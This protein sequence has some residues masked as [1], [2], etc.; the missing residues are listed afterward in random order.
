[1]QNDSNSIIFFI[2]KYLFL[3]KNNNDGEVMYLDFNSFKPTCENFFNGINNFNNLT[4]TSVIKYEDIT[5]VLT[6]EQYSKLCNPSQCSFQDIIDIYNSL[7][8]PENVR[9][10]IQ[11]VREE[12]DFLM[13][14]YSLTQSDIDKIFSAVRF[15]DRSAVYA[16]CDN[17]GSLGE[18]NIN[19]FDL[20][21]DE[22]LLNFID[23]NGYGKYLLDNDTSNQYVVLHD[24][25]IACVNV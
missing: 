20:V 1:M 22:S 6:K 3:Y 13:N 15:K 21:H 19:D 9:L 17:V 25:R 14:K 5:T 8:S 4:I 23:F 24:G 11:I 10:Y 2:N 7:I 12:A 16:V 18:R